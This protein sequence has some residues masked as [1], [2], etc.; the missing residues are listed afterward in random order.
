MTRRKKN[1]TACKYLRYTTGDLY[2]VPLFY[3]VYLSQYLSAWWRPQNF[4]PEIAPI[5]VPS[6]LPPIVS[7]VMVRIS[8]TS[9]SIRLLLSVS[10]R[11]TCAIYILFRRYSKS[12]TIRM[13]VPV[14]R[15]RQINA[16]LYENNQY[17]PELPILT[18]KGIK[19]S[20]MFI[21]N[22]RCDFKSSVMI[23]NQVS[24]SSSS[25]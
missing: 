9:D 22:I 7:D 24:V 17:L 25:W 1:Q 16:D 20:R 18:Q 11:L 19:L 10:L 13:Q 2:Q 14:F 4:P 5:A 12:Q 8:H 15:L 23:Y 3:R 21:R 6:Q